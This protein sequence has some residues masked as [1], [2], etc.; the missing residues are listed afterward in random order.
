MGGEW[1]SFTVLSS[2]DGDNTWSWQFRQIICNSWFVFFRASGCE[3]SNYEKR[4]RA[5]LVTKVNIR[6]RG[7]NVKHSGVHKNKKKLF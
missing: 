2:L 5:L 7:C 3:G 4:K 6:N 1:A